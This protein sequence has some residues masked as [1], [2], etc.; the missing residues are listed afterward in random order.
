MNVSVHSSLQLVHYL[1]TNSLMPPLQSGFRKYHSTESLMTRLLADVFSAVDQGHVTLLARFDVSAAFDTVDHAILLER[2]SK[3]FGIADSAL[4]WFRSFLYDRSL[5]LSLSSSGP[6]ALPG[7]L[8]HMGCLKVQS[9][10]HSSTF[11]IP[12]TFQTYSLS[13]G[14]RLISTLMTP[15]P[16]L[17]VQPA[18]LL[19]WSRVS[20]RPPRCWTF[21]C[22]L[23]VSALI[24]TKLNSSGLAVEPN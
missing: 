16:L 17:M 5:S 24:Q 12:P 3:S 10:H 15:K 6:H 13:K 11:S 9:W 2:L 20:L 22:L 23:T 21:G 8:F 1:D 4:S 14:S 18:Q 7:L 19:H